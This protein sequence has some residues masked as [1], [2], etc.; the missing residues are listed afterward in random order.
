MPSRRD[1][2]KFK[3]S[4]FLETELL[5]RSP[6]SSLP[7]ENNAAGFHGALGSWDELDL[8]PVP[9]ISLS[10]LC[11]CWVVIGMHMGRVCTNFSKFIHIFSERISTTLP[12]TIAGYIWVESHKA[13]LWKWDRH[14]GRRSGWKGWERTCAC[15]Q[16]QLRQGKRHNT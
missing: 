8:K 11:T 6:G 4:A 16:C 1:L 15:S 13:C 9:Q 10:T 5:N 12:W 14:K 2:P 7:N 3:G